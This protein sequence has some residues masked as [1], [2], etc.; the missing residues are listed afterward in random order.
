MGI[1]RR[2]RRKQ[3]TTREVAGDVGTEIAGEF[4]AAGLFR[5]LRGIVSGIVHAFN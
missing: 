5:V 3:S 1:F 4:V 2:N